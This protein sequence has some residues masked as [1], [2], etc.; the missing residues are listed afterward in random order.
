MASIVAYTTA[1]RRRASRGV[2]DVAL[3]AGQPDSLAPWQL[4]LLGGGRP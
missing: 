1:S 3:T 2:A 4:P